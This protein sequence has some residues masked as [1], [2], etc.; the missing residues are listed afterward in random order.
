MHH[1]AT[2]ADLE[3]LYESASPRSLAKETTRL[4]PEYR[5]LIDAA[6]FFALAT[7]GPDGM[8]CSPR[9]DAAPS[10]TIADDSTLHIPDR[11]GNNRLDSLRNIV[12]DGRVALLFL[13]PGLDICLRVNGQAQLTV[14]PELLAQHEVEGR[15][16]RSIIEVS[17]ERV[18]FQCARAIRRAELWNPEA[19]RSADE[20]PTAGDILAAVNAPGVDSAA[21]Y[22][23]YFEDN[24]SLY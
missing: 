24:A 19:Q 12:E 10:V 9:G 1:I 13:I 15:L 21:A 14:D 17:I 5:Q 3:A 23:Q 4:T 11:K 18:Y 6:P 22:D 16:P 2:I 7:V 20:L 8:D